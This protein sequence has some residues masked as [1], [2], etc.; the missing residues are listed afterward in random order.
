MGSA[1]V[2]NIH[3]SCAILEVVDVR[4]PGFNEGAPAST[5]LSTWMAAM[6]K[7]VIAAI[8]AAV[9]AVAGVAI[10]ELMSLPQSAQMLA[11]GIGG[12]VGGAIGAFLATH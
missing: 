10:A 11:A 12:G 3:V 8:V 9:G 1:L 4:H 2:Q 6:N 5:N 7:R